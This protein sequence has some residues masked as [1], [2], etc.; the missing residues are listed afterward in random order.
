MGQPSLFPQPPTPLSQNPVFILPKKYSLPACGRDPLPGSTSSSGLCFQNTSLT[1]FHKTSSP[2]VTSVDNNPD[3]MAV[4]SEKPICP[5]IELSD[6]QQI[7]HEPQE[8]EQQDKE[9]Q[10]TADIDTGSGDSKTEATAEQGSLVTPT[11]DINKSQGMNAVY[12]S[13]PITEPGLLT[14]ELPELA[15]PLE[16][17]S[18]DHSINLPLPFPSSS[19]P[20][21]SLNQLQFPLQKSSVGFSPLIMSCYKEHKEQLVL[22]DSDNE[23]E[24]PECS[25]KSLSCSLLF[26]QT[27]KESQSSHKDEASSSQVHDS[28]DDVKPLP[29]ENG[30]KLSENVVESQRHDCSVTDSASQESASTSDEPPLKRAKLLDTLRDDLHDSVCEGSMDSLPGSKS[31]QDIHV[32]TSMDVHVESSCEA[33][34]ADNISGQT[35]PDVPLPLAKPLTVPDVPLPLAKPLTVPD[36]PLL[37]AKP[38][39]VPGVPLPL[40][41]PLTVPGVP[42]PLAKPLT[43]PDVPLPLAKPL[44]VPDVPLPLAK[45]LTVPDVPLPLTKPLTV[46]D[47]PL[48]LAK[49]LEVSQPAEKSSPSRNVS[50]N[51]IKLEC[52]HEPVDVASDGV[53]TVDQMLPTESAREHAMVPNVVR[54]ASEDDQSNNDR[55]EPNDDSDDADGGSCARL[56]AWTPTLCHSQQVNVI[57]ECVPGQ[58]AVQLKMVDIVDGYSS[59][60]EIHISASSTDMSAKTPSGVYTSALVPTTMESAQLYIE[61]QIVPEESFNNTSLSSQSLYT[62]FH[63]K[64]EKCYP[65]LQDETDLEEMDNS[66]VSDMLLKSVETR[67]T[68]PTCLSGSIDQALTFSPPQGNDLSTSDDELP[69]A[70]GAYSRQS[71]GQSLFGLQHGKHAPQLQGK[72][73][74]SLRA[75]YVLLVLYLFASKIILSS[76]FPSSPHLSPSLSLS[77]S[78]P[79][80]PPPFTFSLLLPIYS[81][82]AAPT[83][84]TTRLNLSRPQLRLGLS[85]RQQCMPLHKSK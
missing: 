16:K 78:P 85:K 23:L 50:D 22:D 13:S 30:I 74:L 57:D 56:K 15:P 47:V 64:N 27:D 80:P 4:I 31:N 29:T 37:P 65:V 28:S 63:E 43:V 34:V 69:K 60:Q 39:T 21:S 33:T 8:I 83:V 54:C 38:L 24:M 2:V 72:L 51:S 62:D 44:T 58:T 3:S 11:L 71:F 42:L 82:S 59:P 25:N 46:P 17:E 7:V 61:H 45:P 18:M 52:P 10:P 19:C 35:V 67:K 49:P 76:S 68:G 75:E 48:L 73:E 26:G 84:A 6:V 55:D 81:G 32:D 70:V 79:P 14:T 36:V 41:K 40:A 1:E 53:D 12:S 20:Q 66:M 77:L 9:E 5:A